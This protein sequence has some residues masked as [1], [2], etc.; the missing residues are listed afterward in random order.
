MKTIFKG[1][2]KDNKLEPTIIPDK[3][4]FEQYIVEWRKIKSD[5]K[6]LKPI[7]EEKVVKLMGGKL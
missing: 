6:K 3:E 1:T 2:F 4:P 5:K 7:K